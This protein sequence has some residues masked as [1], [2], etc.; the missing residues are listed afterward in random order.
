MS[1][2]VLITGA[3]WGIGRG[4]LARYLALPD[5]TVIAANR[6]PDGASSRALSS[7]PR[8]EGTRLEVVKLDASVWQ[9]AFDAVASLES[10]GVADHLDIVI[11]N[12]G[13]SYIWPAVADV[14]LEDIEG[15]IKPNVYGQVALY[16]AARPL[17]RK[18]KREPILTNMGSTAGSLSAPLPFPNAAYGPSK[19]ASAWYTLKIHL[20]D[21]WLHSFSLC[22][23]WVHTDLG[24]AGAKAFGVDEVTQAKFMIG[25]EE[26]CDGMLK[27][28]STTTKAEHGGK[29]VLY[30][31]ETVAW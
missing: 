23:G 9:D 31:G 6:D 26:S 29:L 24:D 16:Q 4:L 5:H 28:L 12:A 27:V 21:D 17:L 7:L 13:V 18:S 11:G 22:P 10:R 8:G 15:H 1:I 25:L 3:N 19:L 20:E 30:N 2:V 14:R